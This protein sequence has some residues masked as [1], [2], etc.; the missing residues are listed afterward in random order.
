MTT[1]NRSMAW[2]L[3]SLW[4][5]VSGQSKKKKVMVINPS[6]LFGSAE[7]FQKAGIQ[8]KC[9][10]HLEIVPSY[11][12]QWVFHLTLS[13]DGLSH[14]QK[15]QQSYDKT[16][17]D[18]TTQS[19]FPQGIK[20]PR[21]PNIL[22][23]FSCPGGRGDTMPVTRTTDSTGAPDK[24]FFTWEWACRKITMSHRNPKSRTNAPCSGASFLNSTFE[25]RGNS[26]KVSVA[27]SDLGSHNA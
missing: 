9:L 1:R 7:H 24:S 25:P 10:R 6:S 22:T 19:S 14:T 11:M 12:S 8:F 20:P 21:D 16:H 3:H 4:T 17:H 5:S 27:A 2:S 18:P 23:G 26:I 13:E 15:P